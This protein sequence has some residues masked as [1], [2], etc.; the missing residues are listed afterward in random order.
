MGWTTDSFAVPPRGG[1][2]DEHRG[3]ENHAPS[4]EVDVAGIVL[5][6]VGGAGVA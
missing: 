1:F 4:A 3:L 6:V 5:F 2:V